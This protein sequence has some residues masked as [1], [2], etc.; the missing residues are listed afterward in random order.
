[1]STSQHES[2][3]LKKFKNYLKERGT[4]ISHCTGGDELLDFL[5]IELQ[6]QPQE[7]IRQ[8]E[9]NILK[10]LTELIEKYQMEQQP[11]GLR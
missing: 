2:E 9:A 6:G 10:C 3:L 11:A 5:E 8:V 1:M 4:D 7:V